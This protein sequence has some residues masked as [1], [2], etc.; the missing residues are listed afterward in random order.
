V[1]RILMPLNIGEA[2]L[3]KGLAIMEEG[4]TELSK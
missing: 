2:E 1:I 4:F 3:E